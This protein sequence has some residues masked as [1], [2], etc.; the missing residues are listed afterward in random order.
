[1]NLFGL[2]SVAVA[3]TV[4]VKMATVKKVN[5]VIKDQANNLYFYIAS[6]NIV[7]NLSC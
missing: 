1:M 3:V 2:D 4:V 6:D 7:L 5:K